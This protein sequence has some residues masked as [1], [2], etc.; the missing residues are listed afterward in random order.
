MTCVSFP[1]VVS[2]VSA[3]DACGSIG[4]TDQI[5]LT[6]RTDRRFYL[7]IN[8]PAT[9]TGTVTSWRVCYYGPDDLRTGSYWATY[10]VYRRM[11][12]EGDER[13]ERV[14]QI[15]SAVRATSNLVG[16]SVV[17]GLIQ[18]DNYACYDDSVDS[19]DSPLTIQAG[20]FLGACVFNPDNVGDDNR[21]QL[22]I[23]GETGGSSLL[24]MN[25]NGCT[26]EAIPSNIP[27]SQ[28]TNGNNRRLHLF[29]NIGMKQSS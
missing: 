13:Y 3:Q 25:D 10:A 20:D 18:E 2:V 14:S 11:G 29:A 21:R 23:V 15:F 28:P 1:I 16:N 4:N 22:N 24:E 12:S 26:T 8:N 27:M 5:E 17:D 7:D 19:G 9:C 6:G